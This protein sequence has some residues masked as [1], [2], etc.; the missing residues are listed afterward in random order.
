[1][2]SAGEVAGFIVALIMAVIVS[3]VLVANTNTDAIL[4]SSTASVGPLVTLAYVAFSIA[5][6]GIVAIVGKYIIGIFS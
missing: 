5:A 1:M 4:G 3:G 6:I 2:T